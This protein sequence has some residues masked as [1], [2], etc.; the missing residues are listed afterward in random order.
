M[1]IFNANQINPIIHRVVGINEIGGKKV[2]STIG[3]N[4]NG[5]ISFETEI[6]EDELVGKPVIK[7]APYLGWVKLVFFERLK[8]PSERGFC[9]EN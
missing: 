6:S 3:D 7:I 1:I 8:S 9:V 4:N 2:F 5:Q